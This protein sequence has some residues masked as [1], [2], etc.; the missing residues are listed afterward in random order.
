MIIIKQATEQDQNAIWAI[1]RQ[2]IAGGDTYAFS[3]DSSREKMLDYWFGADKHTYVAT[4]NEQVVGTFILKNNQPDLGAHVANASY[5]TDPAARG[6]G[7]GKA[8][9]LFSLDEARR[10][11]YRAMQ[12][13]LVVATNTQAVELWQKIGF[14]II[15]EIPE[16]F[17]HH[18][19]GLVNAFIM[20]QKL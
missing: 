8:M 9:G 10:L 18:E 2:V 3:P 16:A 7:V 17:Q 1:I 19:K 5:M 13:N 12:F 15:G 6:Q 20:H 11:G 4:I 14:T